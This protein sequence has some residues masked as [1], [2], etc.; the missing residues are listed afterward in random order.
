LTLAWKL[1]TKLLNAAKTICL[2]S[3]KFELLIGEGYLLM[4]QLNAIYSK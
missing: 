4:Q 3:N 2:A 1:P